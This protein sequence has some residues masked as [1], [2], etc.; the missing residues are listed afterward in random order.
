M[1]Q[2]TG[3]QRVGQNLVTEQHGV[4]GNPIGS[5]QTP[6]WECTPMSFCRGKDDAEAGLGA[7]GIWC[8]CQAQGQHMSYTG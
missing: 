5:P 6:R 7:G 3:L 1:L 2:S 8:G 4:L